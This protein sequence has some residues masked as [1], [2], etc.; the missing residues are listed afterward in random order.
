MQQPTHPPA[1]DD[2]GQPPP[3][4]VEAQLRAEIMRLQ[5]ENRAL[6]IALSEMERVAERDILTP[7][8]NRRYFISALHQRMAKVEKDQD[9]IALVYIDVNGLKAIND[10]HGHGAGDLVLIEI[11]SRLAGTMRNDDVLARIGGDEFGILLNHVNL[12]EA[13][14]WVRRLRMLIEGEPLNFNGA[15]IPLS[16]AFGVTM[17]I[18][19]LSAE[20][21]LGEADNEM[22]RAKRAA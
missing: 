7:L 1:R 18:P 19:G 6:G 5:R 11:A 12:G 10:A 17:L 22:Y 15:D 3:P 4:G 14:A 2:S 8:H 16:A 9:R 21:L 20:E 13:K